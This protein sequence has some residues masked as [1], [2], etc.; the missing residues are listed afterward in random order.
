M[1]AESHHLDVVHLPQGYVYRQF[2]SL[3]QRLSMRERGIG[4]GI[5]DDVERMN[6]SHQRVLLVC[7][8]GDRGVCRNQAG[9]RCIAV[10]RVIRQQVVSRKIQQA[11]MPPVW[12]VKF[13]R[14]YQPVTMCR[15]GIRSEERRVGKECRSRWSPWYSKEKTGQE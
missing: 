6:V 10:G 12:S 4:C 13:L 8:I 3:I 14:M 1:V 9:R 5:D 7:E 2:Q 15:G 11:Q